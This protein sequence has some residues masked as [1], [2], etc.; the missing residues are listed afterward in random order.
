MR[1]IVS[2]PTGSGVVFDYMLLPSLLTSGQRM[3]FNA[4][5]RRVSSAGEPWQAF[6]DP[7]LLVSDLRAMGFRAVEDKGPEAINAQY[8][9][10]RKDR[11]RV[12]GLS[13]VIKAHV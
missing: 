13:H 6:F 2:A 9:R 4:L 5:A 3:V 7:D 10:N 12:G 8:F 1:F 11:L